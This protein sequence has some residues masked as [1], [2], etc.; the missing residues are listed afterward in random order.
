MRSRVGIF[1]LDALFHARA[2][3]R[4]DVFSAPGASSSS[5]HR[6]HLRA[7]SGGGTGGEIRRSKTDASAS[8]QTTDSRSSGSFSRFSRSRSN[9]TTTATTS[10]ND[11]SLSSRNSRSSRS[12]RSG[13]LGRAKHFIKR[14]MPRRGESEE[15]DGGE[16]EQET[17]EFAIMTDGEGSQSEA[18]LRAPPDLGHRA[19]SFSAVDDAYGGRRVRQ[20]V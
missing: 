14:K 9:S 1:G 18:D 12:R 7:G 3:E 10:V 11:S 2:R 4:G 15:E 20:S 13:S 17:D 8:S 5:H 6:P 16:D 19:K